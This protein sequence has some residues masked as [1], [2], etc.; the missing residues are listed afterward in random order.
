MS[1][2]SADIF[3]IWEFALFNYTKLV[4][5]NFQVFHLNAEGRIEKIESEFDT[6]LMARQYWGLMRDG[7]I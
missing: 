2:K 1:R 6:G 7:I 4:V 5:P 3:R